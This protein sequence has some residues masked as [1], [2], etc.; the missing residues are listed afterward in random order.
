MMD[1][2]KPSFNFLDLLPFQLLGG[3]GIVCALLGYAAGG[4]WLFL[5]IAVALVLWI[6]AI[7]SVPMR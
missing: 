5:G 1:L 3:L 6:V 4:L 7:R 2:M